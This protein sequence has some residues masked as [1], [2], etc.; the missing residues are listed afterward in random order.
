MRLLKQRLVT[1]ALVV[2]TSFLNAEAAL[3]DSVKTPVVTS[4]DLMADALYYDAIKARQKGDDKEAERILL[5]VIKAKPNEGGAYYDLAN[6]AFKQNRAG[7]ATQYIKKA[8]ALNDSNQW[9]KAKY[10]E[11]LVLDNKYEEAANI[12]AGLGRTEKY[13]EGYILLAARFYKQA[14][15][16]KNAMAQ[17]DVLLEKNPNSEELLTQEQELYLKMNDVDGAVKVAQKLIDNNPNEGKYYANLAELY[18]NNDKHS[19]AEEIYEKIEERFGDDAVV[20]LALADNYKKKNNMPKYNEY[21]KKV[22]LNKSLD[23]DVQIN[24]LAGYWQDNLTDSLKRIEI[25]GLARELAAQHPNHAAT[26]ATYAQV[27][28]ANGNHLQSQ[29]QYKK[30]VQIDPSRFGVWQ[31]LLFGYTEKSEADSLLVYSEKA[32]RLFPNQAIFHYLNGIGN[33]NKGENNK[34]IK[35]INRAIDMEPENNTDQISQMYTTLGDL[36]N[37]MKQYAK[38]D[39]AYNYALKLDPNNATLLNNYSYYLSVRNER[40]DEAEKMSK[41]SLEIRKDEPTFLDTYGW[42]LYKEHQ[43]ENAKEYIQKAIDGLNGDAD[44]TVWEHLGDVYYK[45]N[46]VDKAVECWKKAKEKGSENIEIDKK[47]KDRKLYES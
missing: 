2:I 23:A 6:I 33:M 13:N 17:L 32:L 14:N 38:S 15:K 41:K 22:I 25:E 19:K 20:Q 35:S 47:I 28:S 5:Q 34:A 43:Y 24:M 36:Y 18:E 26:V 16:L 8:I 42:I 29:E 30:A 1:A 40:L 46:Q 3:P 10:A 9:Y 37:T 45:L 31:N 7:E 27:L 4:P 12:Y 44:A 11:I 21:V 39:S